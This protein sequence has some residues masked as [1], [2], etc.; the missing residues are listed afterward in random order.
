MVRQAS[1]HRNQKIVGSSVNWSWVDVRNRISSGSPK[2]HI[3]SLLHLSGSACFISALVILI[4]SVYSF[5]RL[6]FIAYTWSNMVTSS[7]FDLT[8]RLF[9]FANCSPDP[10]LRNHVYSRWDMRI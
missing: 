10:Q 2:G 9:P 1:K 5:T 8:D 4:P 3:M 6:A 7:L